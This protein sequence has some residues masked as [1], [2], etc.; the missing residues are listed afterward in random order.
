MIF[1]KK[2]EVEIELSEEDLK[3]LEKL[4]MLKKRYESLES[5]HKLGKVSDKQFKKEEYI[6]SCEIDD[7]EN[8][9][10]KIND[11]SKDLLNGIFDS[12][13]RQVHEAIGKCEKK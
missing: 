3:A 11:M 9:Q 6:I 8:K 1:K 2:T 7:L 4:E 12:Y 5:D 10:G 13:D